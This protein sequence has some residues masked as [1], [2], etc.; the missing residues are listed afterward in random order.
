MTWGVSDLWRGECDCKSRARTQA[1]G[2]VAA[3]AEKKAT[4]SEVKKAENDAAPSSQDLQDAQD[5]LVAELEEA[6]RNNRDLS[7]K[8]EQV[9]AFKKSVAELEEDRKA[10]EKT[11]KALE[12]A[13]HALR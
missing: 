7:E 13:A 8:A 3:G 4:S 9:D 10:L 1:A 11:R 5:G 6:V 2:Y 12:S